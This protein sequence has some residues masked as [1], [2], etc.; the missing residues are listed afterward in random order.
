M[1]EKINE[2]S[3]E[4][5]DRVPAKTPEE[6]M[7]TRVEEAIGLLKSMSNALDALVYYATPSR[8]PGTA[9]LEKSIGSSLTQLGSGLSENQIKGSEM[10]LAERDDLSTRRQS[11]APVTPVEQNPKFS[12]RQLKQK[13]AGL[14]GD[15]GSDVEVES[16]LTDKRRHTKSDEPILSPR[17]QGYGIASDRYKPQTNVSMARGMGDPHTRFGKWAQDAP[18]RQDIR[19]ANYAQRTGAEGDAEYKSVVRGGDDYVRSRATQATGRRGG[20]RADVAMTTGDQGYELG[21]VGLST[22]P[23]GRMRYRY[24]GKDPTGTV[25]T[26]FRLPWRAER[27]KAAIRQAPSAHAPRGGLE[28]ATQI[29]GTELKQIVAEELEKIL[30]EQQKHALGG[31]SNPYEKYSMPNLV[32][33]TGDTPED[34]VQEMQE[35]GIEITDETAA[36]A[37]MNAGV[38]DDDLPDFVDAIME[39][40][41]HGDIMLHEGR[42]ARVRASW[43]SPLSE[44]LYE[45]IEQ[46]VEASGISGLGKMWEYDRI[47]VD[48]VDEWF[49][50]GHFGEDS[51]EFERA[52]MEVF[53]YVKAMFP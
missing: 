14:S 34:I 32:S 36:R 5:R 17:K 35:A 28:E 22:G 40:A 41:H 37:A 4:N 6:T 25:T 53:Q 12:R 2:Y 46:S 10:T 30:Y 19:A 21:Q 23:L 18:I 8:S 31:P 47:L 45:M 16:E 26:G 27:A 44:P 1:S 48:E 39:I 43:K 24:A 42:S 50:E 29:K 20:K 11:S 15:L 38:V 52:K 33:L 13:V 9:G 7:E 3:E 49:A 51:E